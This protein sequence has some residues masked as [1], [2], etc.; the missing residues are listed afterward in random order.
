MVGLLTL[1]LLGAGQ[2][3][4]Q[5]CPLSAKWGTQMPETYQ[6]RVLVRADGKQVQYNAGIIDD[7]T[8][9][10]WVKIHTKVKPLPPLILH[11]AAA[12]DCRRLRKLARLIEESIDCSPE[13]CIVVPE[14]IAV[15]MQPPPA[16]P[17]RPRD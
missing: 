2:P 15:A 14:R 7:I 1:A 5:A 17:P 12:T 16:P 13:A 9:R 11:D 4:G 8:A 6:Y 3:A 10:E